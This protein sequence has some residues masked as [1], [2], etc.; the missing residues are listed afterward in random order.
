MHRYIKGLVDEI[1]LWDHALN[2]R[3]LKY[4]SMYHINGWHK[5]F[6]H[7]VFYYKFN[8]ATGAEAESLWVDGP[9]TVGLHTSN[10]VAPPI[11]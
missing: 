10:A 4:W 8:I 3:D 9:N 1:R 5:S 7:L 11:A 6:V 2:F